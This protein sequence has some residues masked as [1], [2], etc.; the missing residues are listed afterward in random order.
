MP[1]STRKARSSPWRAATPNVC[2]NTEFSS[3]KARSHANRPPENEASRKEPH[4]CWLDRAA[5]T[6]KRQNNRAQQQSGL[7]GRNRTATG[8]TGPLLPRRG[9]TTEPRVGRRLKGKAYPGYRAPPSPNPERV[10]QENHPSA[11]SVQRNVVSVASNGTN[12]VFSRN[13]YGCCA[14]L[15]GL[16]GCGFVPRVGRPRSGCGQPWASLSCPVGARRSDVP[17]A[18]LLTP[19]TLPIAHINEGVARG[20]PF[21]VFR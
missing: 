11:R 5:S 8:W 14:T 4:R 15:S 21:G 13:G 12:D 2:A 10:A 3:R 9:R 17:A 7:P 16:A 19:R 6:S 20:N 18:G 1:E